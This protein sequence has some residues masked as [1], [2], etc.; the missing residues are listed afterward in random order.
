[1]KKTTQHVKQHKKAHHRNVR[2][3]TSSSKGKSRSSNA[4]ISHASHKR[5]RLGN[6]SQKRVRRSRGKSWFPTAITALASTA[7]GIGILS[8]LVART[9]IDTIKKTLSSFY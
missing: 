7:A 6:V 3:P 5:A 4:R 2:R 8:L 9:G 1:M